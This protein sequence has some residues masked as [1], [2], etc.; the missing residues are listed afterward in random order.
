M[1]SLQ[2]EG[3][4][5]DEDDLPELCEDTDDDMPDFVYGKRGGDDHNAAPHMAKRVR[6][7]GYPEETDDVTEQFLSR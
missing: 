2:K 6:F 1:I 3:R 4:S 5:N 7:T